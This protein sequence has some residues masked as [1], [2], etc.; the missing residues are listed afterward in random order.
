MAEQKPK[1]QTFVRVVL[2]AGG[3]FYT[4]TGVALFFAPQWFYDHIGTYPP[5]N[6]HYEG[7]LG[8]IL[9]PMGIAMVIAARDPARHR[10]LFGV[11][12][13]GSIIHAVNHLL[14]ELVRSPSTSQ[15]LTGSIPLTIFAAILVAAYIAGMSRRANG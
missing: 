5:F 15:L 1:Q 6:H 8:A 10:L 11:I 13:A 7:D 12:V 9:M 4:L 3:I 14:D 2:V